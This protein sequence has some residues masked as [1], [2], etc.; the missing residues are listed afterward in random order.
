[1]KKIRA[2][3][4][5]MKNE[6]EIIPLLMEGG[7]IEY[8]ANEEWHFNVVSKYG[9]KK[10][11]LIQDFHN[12]RGK[13]IILLS[14]REGTIHFQIWRLVRTGKKRNLLNF[15]FNPTPDE[16][17]IIE[18]EYDI[19]MIRLKHPTLSQ[20]IINREIICQCKDWEESLRCSCNPYIVSRRVG[21][22]YRCWQMH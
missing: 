3:K 9:I 8:D 18:R 14:G 4:H 10:S 19:V 20:L 2:L 5:F 15:I 1:M 21:W 13:G 17:K 6:R 22:T 12:L 7:Y 16:D 11:F